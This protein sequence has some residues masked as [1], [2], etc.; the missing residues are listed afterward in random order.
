MKKIDFIYIRILALRYY[1][2]HLT[3]EMT[4]VDI[5]FDKFKPLIS[6]NIKHFDI[7]LENK[8]VDIDLLISDLTYMLY[9][10][11][12]NDTIFAIDGL[13]L[14]QWE[15]FKNDTKFIN[16]LFKYIRSFK[17][18]KINLYDTKYGI[19]LEEVLKNIESLIRNDKINDFLN[20]I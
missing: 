19:E 5:I 3:D 15:V 1:Y 10:N 14:N 18:R 13:S 6:S 2:M 20:S 11:K 4:L 9:D 12:N 16:E 8:E 17:Y 7:M